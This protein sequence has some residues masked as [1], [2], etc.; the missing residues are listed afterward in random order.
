MFDCYQSMKKTTSIILSFII[1]ALYIGAFAAPSADAILKETADKLTKA[2]SVTAE[3]TISSGKNKDKGT[4]I[5]ASGKFTLTSSSLRTWYDGLTLWTY[6]P[7]L[8]EVNI[9]HPTS[10]ELMDINPFAIIS[11]YKQQYSAKIVATTQKDVYAV[12]LT[13]KSK[14]NAS[15][16]KAVLIIDKTT[17]YPKEV[18]LIM[19]DKSDIKIEVNSVTTGNL[20]SQRTFVFDQSDAPDAE[21]VDL[22]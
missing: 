8:G 13:P 3:Y 11:T 5:L 15:F 17:Y 7:E 2:R 16:S 1:S 12:E 6:S 4:I 20:I 21:I 22:R 18:T 14:R 9:T 10:D 19:P